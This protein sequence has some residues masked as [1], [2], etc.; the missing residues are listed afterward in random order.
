MEASRRRSDRCRM[1]IM[2]MVVMV[3]ELFLLPP[4]SSALTHRKA[5]NF[6]KTEEPGGLPP[7]V[8]LNV[9]DDYVVIDNGIVRAT[10]TIPDGQLVKISYGGA[11]NLLEV[12]NTEDNRGYWDIVWGKKVSDSDTYW[13][14]GSSFKII[15]EDDNQTEIS[16][17]SKWDPDSWNSSKP[18]LPI[19][20]DKRYIMLRGSSGFYS[21]TI[22][23]REEGWPQ[24]NINQIRAVFKLRG[25]MF[26]Y[27]AVANDI[28]KEMPTQSDR[29]TGELLAFKEAVLL[30][31]P[32]NP[33]LKGEVDDKYQ[34]S[35]DYKDNKV[36]G[37][38]SNNPVVGFWMIIPS[39]EFRTGGPVKQD[40]TSHTGPTTLA[41]FHSTHY[42]GMGVAMEFEEGEPWKMVFGPF[43]IY[44]NSPSHGENYHQ[45]WHDANVQ[46]G[47]EVKSWPY[48]F[49]SSDDFPKPDQRGSVDGRLLVH[50]SFDTNNTVVSACAA[51]VG[52][53]R[54]G[55]AG[56]WQTETKGYQFW[57]K[58]DCSGNFKIQGI[59]EGNYS[60]YGWVPGF[61]GDYKYEQDI[62]ITAGC[63]ISLG[64]LIFKPSRNGPTLWQIGIPDR[65]A[66]E[67]Y[68]PKPDPKYENTVF[69]NSNRNRFRQYGLW[70]RYSELY[71][72]HD[73][74]YTVGLSDY[75]KD[76]FFAQVTREFE[77]STLS[78]TTW[79]IKFQL[80]D[81]VPSSMY[82]LRI[83]LAAASESD[84]QVWFNRP[85]GL[86][87]PQFGTHMIGRDNAI[88]RHGIHG[89]HWSCDID[90]QSEWL[91]TGNNT[92]YLRQ[93]RALSPFE[94]IMYDFIRFEGPSQ[95]TR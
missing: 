44:L 24:V 90:V 10:W 77:N 48:T 95:S 85:P 1:W 21:Y 87:N 47:K 15:R 56:S 78:G 65:T 68:V 71:P 7:P 75:H 18:A 2:I 60:L 4:C 57:T 46:M 25:E 41:M 33:D 91:Q 20:F 66:A 12:Q 39:T 45:L 70:K 35:L 88:A 6:R 19:N 9:S 52:L 3:A 76:W 63:H 86:S 64:N 89:L 29:E 72:D 26:H 62:L 22:L 54:P 61:S 16:F 94:G 49:P 34:Y 80:D 23:E 69:S 67:F 31:N 55:E 27:M 30:T 11:D 8:T 79:Q 58:A 51:W 13:L 14:I 93:L 83:A 81:L 36:H 53:A 50:D 42:A 32:S 40:L 5:G 43:L 84:L 59:R 74:V 82:T 17:S 38:I 73:L 28:Q 92:I 37:W